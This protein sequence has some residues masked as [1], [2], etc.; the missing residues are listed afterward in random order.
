LST[1]SNYNNSIA[2]TTMC[3]DDSYFPTPSDSPMVY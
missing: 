2:T 3:R 1:N